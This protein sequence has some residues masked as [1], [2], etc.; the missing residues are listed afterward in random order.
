MELKIK[1]KDIIINDLLNEKIKNL[2]NKAIKNYDKDKIIE[3]ENEIKLFR[4]Y[5]KFKDNEKLISVQIISGY[6]DIHD[7]Y[8]IAKNTDKF[9]KLE[10][11]LYEVYPDYEDSENY[12]LV[13]GNKIKNH[14]TLEQNNIKN[15]DVIILQKNNLD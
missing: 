8:R 7:F 13:N 2:E 9:S 11:S 5:Y 6:Q 15:N 4:K 1:E 14:K 10:T 12:F 3:L